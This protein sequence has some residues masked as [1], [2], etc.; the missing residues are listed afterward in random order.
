MN[1]QTAENIDM[2]QM[3]ELQ[4]L[5]YENTPRQYSNLCKSVKMKISLKCF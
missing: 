1:A 3:S 4:R 2:K 5:H